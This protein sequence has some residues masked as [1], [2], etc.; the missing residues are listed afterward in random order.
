MDYKWLREGSMRSIPVLLEDM[1]SK[2]QDK[3]AIVYYDKKISYQELNSI[4]LSV[5]LYVKKFSK[6]GDRVAILMP[7]I[8]QFAFCYY[9][10]LMANH[11]AV[12]VNFISIADDL[13]AQK[14]VS[15]IKVTK[16]I[17]AQIEDSKP[18]IIF[19]ADFLYPILS[20]IRINWDC[21][22]V[23]TSPG[24]YLPWQLKLLYPLK[25]RKEGRSIKRRLADADWF[26]E[27]II[28]CPGGL[29]LE[30]VDPSD[31]AQFQYTGGTTGTPKA[32]M[33][34]HRNLVSN[35]L[36]GREHFGDLLVDGQEVVLGALPFFH[37]Y[38]LTTCLNLT[39]LSLGGTLVLMPAF[40][41][42]LAIKYI[43][44]YKVTMFSGVN[45]MYQ[46]V[47][48]QE[49]LLAKADVSS[50]K[51]CISGAG[52]IDKSIC[53]KFKEITKD[54][55]IV[56]GYGL[57]E[58]SPVVSVTRPEDLSQSRPAGFIGKPLPE[59]KVRILSE[60]GEDLPIGT[61]GEIVV[62]GPQVMSGY[63][64]KP[65]ETKAVLSGGA[66]DWFKTG[67]VG[68]V[69]QEGYLYFTD[70]L[71]DVITVMG[72]NV[73]ASHIEKRLIED[74]KIKE[75]VVVGMPDIKVGE[76]PV[77][78]VVLQDSS[79]DKSDSEINIIARI[80]SYDDWEKYF[81]PSRIV[82]VDSLD[83][84]KNSIGKISKIK[85]KEY[86]KSL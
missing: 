11:I 1:A 83:Q 84:F 17:V 86:L 38:G 32:A 18:A 26:Q 65:D 48:N 10:T 49:E 2:M 82:I 53:D 72:E 67:D 55:S 37:I 5:S 78:L 71:K 63:Y 75:A 9:G 23:L 76:T 27:D 33:L 43:E 13:K 46:A 52:P 35:I 19:A 8:P 28:N 81:R 85:I 39:L 51:L 79:W 42:K 59:T 12:P 21:K 34:T 16:D 66:E 40:D 45:R 69:D 6:P 70:R 64:N 68:Y 62:C 30:K 41:P 22:I 25:A 80:A 54:I 36:Q 74:P 50:L 60:N 47:V 77:A 61:I 4:S 56:E 3:P 58:T 14:P 31:V 57:S 20:Q 7:N 24:E 29:M 15:E 44:K 73:Y